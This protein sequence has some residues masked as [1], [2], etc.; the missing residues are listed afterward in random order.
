MQSRCNG[1]G[2]PRKRFKYTVQEMPERSMDNLTTV[3]G[4]RDTADKSPNSDPAT[5]A[6]SETI[7]EPNNKTAS[8]APSTNSS[9]FEKPASNNPIAGTTT[10]TTA[11]SAE[12]HS[13]N[14]TALCID[15]GDAPTSD[16]GAD[17]I[18]TTTSSLLPNELINI[19]RSVLDE[20]SN[21][22]EIVLEA[23]KT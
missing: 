4:V 3:D 10:G 15:G 1:A 23:L 18:E 14:T 2:R 8:A 9:L 21:S 12:D 19:K 7:Q 5:N 6:L 22:L 17:C 13:N 16:L 11:M 20:S